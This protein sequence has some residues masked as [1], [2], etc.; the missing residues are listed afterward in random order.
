[1]S[2]RLICTLFSGLFLLS[3]PIASAA[4][5]PPHPL[6]PLLWKIEGKDLAKA[7]YLFGTIH[8]GSGPLATLHPAAEKA[9]QECNTLY[10][11]IPLDPQQQLAMTK[12][13]MRNDKKTLAQSIGVKLKDLVEAELQAINPALDLT[14]FNPMKTWVMAVSLPSLKVQ[15]AGGASMDDNLWKRAKKSEKQTGSLETAESQLAIFDQFKEE[16]QIILLSETIRLMKADRD[17]KKDSTKIIIDAYVSGEIDTIKKEMDKGMEEMTKGEHK[18]LGERLCQ[19]LITDRDR[20]MA[21]TIGTKLAEAP[22]KCHFF[23]VGAGHFAGEV[24]IRSHLEK[25][26]YKITR[27]QE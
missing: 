10:T 21:A 9:F 19:K 3:E 4:E 8:I 6:K 16:E 23:A 2:L 25:Q 15:L 11:E 17:E 1:M 24:S 12:K 7:S 27:I 20:S 26:G 13:L 5:A 22:A 14:P 18:E